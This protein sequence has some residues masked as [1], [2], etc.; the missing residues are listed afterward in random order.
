MY[1][2]IEIDNGSIKDIL[3]RI[4]RAKKELYECYAELDGM[5]G[6]TQIRIFPEEVKGD[7]ED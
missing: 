2:Y 5:Q 4:D 1:A 6:V 3:E 7:S